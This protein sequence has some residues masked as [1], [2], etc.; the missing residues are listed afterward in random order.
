MTAVLDNVL[1]KLDNVQQHGSYHM[2]C[3]PAHDD[4]NP[5]LKISVN[6][7]GWV[8]F[9]C[10]AGCTQA[11]ILTALNMENRD[12]VP[13]DRRNGAGPKTD[14][15]IVT[16][17]DYL[18]E[19]SALLFQAVRF[20][21]KEFRQRRP[22][23][24]G[25]WIFDLKGVRRILYRLPELL[26]ADPALPVFLVEGE[27][28]VDNLRAVGLVATCNPMGASKWNNEYTKALSGRR[29]VLLPDNDEPGRKHRDLVTGKLAGHVAELKIV[30]LPDLPDHGDVSD[31]LAA[32]GID[33][34]K[35]VSTIVVP[36]P[37]MVANMKVDAMEAFCVGEPWPLQTVNQGIGY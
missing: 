37:Q 23:G 19:Q 16:T 4:N 24:R 34:D 18:D 6:R 26:A 30:D 8:D 27:K 11:Q 28:D 21:P 3:C 29:V 7:K 20:D 9:K 35:D 5:S 33:P 1:A 17:Y 25:G 31:W 14:R 36:P 15:R 32:G 10:F 13:E 12:L 22:D 2:A